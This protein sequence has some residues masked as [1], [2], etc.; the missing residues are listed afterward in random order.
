MPKP[1]QTETKLKRLQALRHEPQSPVHL[2]ELRQA[3]DD[4]SNLVAAE[5]VEIIGERLLTDL[6]P[7]LAAAFDRFMID[8]E[9]TDKLCR[10]KIAIVEAINKLEVDNEEL[11]LRGVVHVQMEPRWGGSDDTAGPLRGQCAFGLVRTNHRDLLNILADLLADADKSARSM[12]AQALAESRRSGAISMLRLKARIGD[13]E[14]D[15]VAECLSALMSA[16]A[17]ESL[18]F[19]AGF[20]AAGPLT[21]Q[22]AAALALGESRQPEAL[23]ILIQYYARALADSV[24]SATLLAISMTR[25]PAGI[26][27][28]L[29]LLTNQDKLSASSAMSALAIHRH[30]PTIKDRVTVA[31]QSGSAELRQLLR[32]KFEARE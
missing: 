12:A 25:L 1:R 27:F 16:D 4:R 26:D 8:A 15:V 11:F 10:A 2:A 6:V 29:S 5:A 3:V 9:E 32:K 7:E 13:K 23:D 24:R 17:K 18:R 22:E 30:N 19:V 14:P 31:V 20:L 28:L 21:T